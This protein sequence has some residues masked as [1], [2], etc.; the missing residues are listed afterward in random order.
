MSKWDLGALGLVLLTGLLGLRRGLL[1][2]ALGIAGVVGGALIG[3]RIGPHFLNGGRMSAY[4]PVA[5]LAGAI[6][7]AAV[8][9][10]IG[11]MIGG[12]LRTSMWTMPPLRV[13]DSAGGFVLGAVAGLAIVWVVGSVLLQLP[14]EPKLRRKAQASLVLQRLYEIAPPVDLLHLLSRVDPFPALTTS[15]PLVGPPDVSASRA[16][17]VAKAGASVVRVLGS[18]CGLGVQGSGWVARRGFVVTAAHV[19]AGEKDTKVV[20]RGT[21][22]SLAAKA[23]AFDPGNDLAVLYVPGLALPPLPFG[24][25][26]EGMSV[27]IL[28]F[29]KNGPFRIRPGRIGPTATVLSEDAYGRGPVR[30][31]I[32]SVRGLV[33][34]GS[35]GG[36]AVDS[37]GVVRT[38]IFAARPGFHGGYGIP[39]ALLAQELSH[40]SRTV[41]TG[42]CVS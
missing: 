25:P 6:V 40:A 22:L 11:A 20:L 4:T 37:G 34:H 24:N 2:G 14:N 16:A 38:T 36:P 15:L 41:S 28:G 5:A 13:F 29:P 30:R 42:A 35:S 3:S 10:T 27:A 32:T 21:G 12:M 18:A 33:R 1:A 9:S 17:A 26:E 8:G 23:V 31:T 39:P 7:L 19:V